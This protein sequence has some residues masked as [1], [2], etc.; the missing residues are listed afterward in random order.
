MPLT[1]AEYATLPFYEEG[2]SYDGSQIRGDAAEFWIKPLL[3]GTTKPAIITITIKTAGLADDETISVQAT[4]AIKLYRG[5][6]ILFPTSDVLVVVKVDT[7]I[8]TTPTTLPVLPLTG[9]IAD[10]EA[11]KTYGLYPVLSLSEGGIPENTGSEVGSRNRSESLYQ[12]KEIIGRD[13]SLTCNGRVVSY[14][15]GLWT[16]KRLARGRRRVYWESRYAPYLSFTDET[17][18]IH[19]QGKGPAAE[20][21]AAFV[22]NYS[23]QS[24]ADNMQQLQA[25]LMG[26]GR[27]SD[28]APLE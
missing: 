23:I 5:D 26:T 7:T 2:V 18:T 20:T 16:L 27:P 19:T 21:G 25:S 9:A 24:N 12:V 14:D 13:Y 3:P 28:Y 8:A 11:A 1:L 17:G 15:P 10:E 4:A 22:Q 6:V